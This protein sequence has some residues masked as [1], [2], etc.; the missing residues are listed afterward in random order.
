MSEYPTTIP[1]D[2]ESK[3][4]F[5]EARVKEIFEASHD[6]DPTDLICDT[7]S[8]YAE[9]MQQGLGGILDAEAPF[10]YAAC[11]ALMQGIDEATPGAKKTGKSA[12]KAVKS[13]LAP[14]KVYLHNTDEAPD[15]G[16]FPDADR[17]FFDHASDL[18][19]EFDALLGEEE[20]NGK[21]RPA[22]PE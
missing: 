3:V 22:D 10:I 4:N 11:K 16:K 20:K 17:S 5:I 9:M 19:K 18:L 8:H 14:E 1:N 21:E 6:G 12:Y 15:L 2:R 7:V 13:N